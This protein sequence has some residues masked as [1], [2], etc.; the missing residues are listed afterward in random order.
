[1][2]VLWHWIIFIFCF[3]SLFCLKNNFHFKRRL[4]VELVGKFWAEVF[5]FSIA[6]DLLTL[7]KDSAMNFSSA[8]VKCHL[9]DLMN[10]LRQSGLPFKS[11][12]LIVIDGDLLAGF[13]KHRRLWRNVEK[14]HGYWFNFFVKNPR[15]SI[16]KL[17]ESCPRTQ[18]KLKHVEISKKLRLIA[19]FAGLPIFAVGEWLFSFTK[20]KLM[21]MFY[22]YRSY[23]SLQ[24]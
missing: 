19:C 16:E 8:N 24:Y 17:I 18:W 6:R 4:T 10:S 1:M 9:V 23:E 12:V 5:N 21:K 13:F 7:E 3:V 22:F 14:I 20:D 2:H 11:L 15:N